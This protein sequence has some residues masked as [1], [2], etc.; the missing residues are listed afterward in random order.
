L[1]LPSHIKTSDVFDVRHL[2]PY[3]GDSTRKDD[4]NSR[5]SLP[6]PGGTDATHMEEDFF[7]NT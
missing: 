4:A 7:T 3:H 2:I 6:S 1:K 5:A